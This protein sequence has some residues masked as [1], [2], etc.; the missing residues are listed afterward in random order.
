MTKRERLYDRIT[1]VKIEK[2]CKKRGFL[3]CH[4]KIKV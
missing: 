4:Y 1:M 3:F 2:L